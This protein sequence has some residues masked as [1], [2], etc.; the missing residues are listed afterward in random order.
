M[1]HGLL[2]GVLMGLFFITVSADKAFAQDK[3]LYSFNVEEFEKKSWEWSGEF[4]LLGTNKTYNKN[5]VLHPLKFPDDEIDQ[6]QEVELQL[7]LESRWD[8]DWSRFFVSGEASVIRSSLEENDDETSFLSEGYLQ[9]N[10]FDPQSFEIGKRLL[11]WGKG[12]AFNPV[13]LM[14]RVKNP[15]DPEASREGLWITQGILIPGG[16]SIFENTSVTLVYLPIREEINEDYQTRYEYDNVWGMKL[17]GLIGTTDFDL[18]LVEWTE[19]SETD[20]GID[21]ATNITPSFEVHGE[22]AVFDTTES[23][24]QQTLIGLRYLTENEITLIVEGFNDSSGLTYNESKELYQLIEVSPADKAK[25][26]LS[27]IQQKKTLNRNYGYLK[28]SIKEPFDWLYF[29]PSFTW[30]GNLDDRSS[31]NALQLVYAPSDNLSYQLVLQYLEGEKYSQFGE[32]TV[33]NKVELSASY[34]F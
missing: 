6:S 8:W 2:L 23:T 1:K 18:Y 4:R 32:N 5:S 19:T 22:L 13:A 26:Y 9:L 31:S 7:Y 24:E 34:D 17:Y 16:F 25:P 27:Q 20:L 29:T 11:R 3:D 21:F 28:I 10:L 30:L 15:E 14:E 33:K 12:Y